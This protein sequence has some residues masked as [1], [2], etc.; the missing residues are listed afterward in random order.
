MGGWMEM[1]DILMAI[2]KLQRWWFIC[3][4][5]ISFVNQADWNKICRQDVWLL[6]LLTRWFICYTL[7][8]NVQIHPEEVRLVPQIRASSSEWSA[9]CEL[10]CSCACDVMWCGLC[11]QWAVDQ[12]P[13]MQTLQCSCWRRRPSHWNRWMSQWVSDMLLSVQMNNWKTHS[14]IISVI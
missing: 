9:L 13:L 12:S 4:T 10:L 14:N 2:Y 1:T 7:H 3:A 6:L 8:I 5:W 11:L